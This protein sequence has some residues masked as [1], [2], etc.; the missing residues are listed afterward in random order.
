MV[1]DYN[2]PNLGLNRYF[3]HIFTIQFWN[4]I[5][6][7]LKFLKNKKYSQKYLEESH[8]CDPH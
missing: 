7:D 6:L 1:Y 8:I 4:N 2:Y 3:H 5:P